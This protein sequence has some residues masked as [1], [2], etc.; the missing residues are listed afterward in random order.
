MW[1]GLGWRTA[2]RDS[3]GWPQEYRPDAATANAGRTAPGS[4]Q[5]ATPA[6]GPLAT[7]AP[8]GRGADRCACA[9]LRSSPAPPGRPTPRLCSGCWNLQEFSYLQ[10]PLFFQ[11]QQTIAL[12]S[13]A[14]GAAFPEPRRR[15]ASA[16]RAGVGAGGG[17]LGARDGSNATV[18]PGPT[19][20]RRLM[21]MQPSSRRVSRMLTS[22]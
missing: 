14:R 10:K 4:G 5:L 1:Q 15:S 18:P 22:K 7:G 9:A 19:S 12:A 8:P 6:S 21:T 20:T 16:A 11:W 2:P 17:G 3:Q 13:T